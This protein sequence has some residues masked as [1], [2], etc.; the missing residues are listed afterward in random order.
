MKPMYKL[1]TSSNPVK[2]GLS[3][4]NSHCVMVNRASDGSYQLSDSKLGDDS[5]VWALSQ[6]QFRELCRVLSYH[7]AVLAGML[8]DG[9]VMIALPDGSSCAF[10]YGPD[11]EVSHVRS[12]KPW[13]TCLLSTSTESMAFSLEEL[14]ALTW[15]YMN[16]QFPEG[17]PVRQVAA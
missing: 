7:I 15:G 3:L 9:P 5:P 12:G 8:Y 14:S 16:G 13:V 6:G 1:V 2:S 17:E 11:P 4:A 10:L